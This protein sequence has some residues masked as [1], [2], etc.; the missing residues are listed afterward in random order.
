MQ[1]NRYPS[2]CICPIGHF[3]TLMLKLNDKFRLNLRLS[4][5]MWGYATRGHT[6]AREF[7]VLDFEN[8]I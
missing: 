6:N 5:A 7:I 4:T 2:K 1:R 3:S 8:R